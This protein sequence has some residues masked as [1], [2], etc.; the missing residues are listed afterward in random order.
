MQNFGEIPDLKE[1]SG[2]K[3]IPGFREIPVCPDFSF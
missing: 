1:I 2:F 3:E